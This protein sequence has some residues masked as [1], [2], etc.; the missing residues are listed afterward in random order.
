MNKR[1]YVVKNTAKILALSS[2]LI[3]KPCY[4]Y[5]SENIQEV[6]AH[7]EWTIRFN[8]IIDPYSVYNNIV[9][10]DSRGN[11]LSEPKF[12]ILENG[13]VVKLQYFNEIYRNSEVY[14]LT[15][16]NNIK[17]LKGRK[18]AHSKFIKFRV[19]NAL[20]NDSE[21]VDI[22]EC[23]QKVP[24]MGQSKLLSKNMAE[25][26]LKH[27]KNPKV[28]INIYD[29][30]NIFLEE[31]K[32]EGVRGD[33]A[34]CQ[35]IKE[36][37][38]FKYGGQVLPEQNNYAGIG[39][40]NNTKVG[41]GA[42]FKSAKEGVRAQIQHLKGYATREKLNNMCIDPRYNILKEV[43]ILGIA[44]NWQNLNGRWAVPGKNY[45]EDIISIYKRIEKMK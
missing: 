40:L 28:S 39:A 24:I 11:I 37:G 27:N 33:I 2:L 45:G 29:L 1:L 42:W 43:G 23:T 10:K 18:L 34:F 25:Y 7:K 12:T 22:S 26:V 30:A 4:S 8:R 16:T 15:V 31:G 21:Y 13:Q 6:D 19:K 36:T 14:T 44:P 20:D 9:V 35:S 17:D 41:K 32:C 38:F 3:F 5:A